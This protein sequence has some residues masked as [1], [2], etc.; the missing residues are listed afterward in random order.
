M[1]TL[2]ANETT[3]AVDVSTTVDID[4]TTGAIDAHARDL[5]NAREEN[6][7]VHRGVRSR[8]VNDLLVGK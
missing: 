5:E 6:L 4:H 1:S 2:V 3:L 8:G 7:E